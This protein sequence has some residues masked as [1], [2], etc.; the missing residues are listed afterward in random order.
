MESQENQRKKRTETRSTVV[1][2]SLNLNMN[3]HQLIL[4]NQSSYTKRIK[5]T[6]AISILITQSL[7]SSSTATMSRHLH[8]TIH[9]IHHPVVTHHAVRDL[10]QDIETVIPHLLK[11]VIVEHLRKGTILDL[12]KEISMRKELGMR[13]T[14]ELLKELGMRKILE[15]LKE[16]DIEIIPGNSFIIDLVTIMMAMKLGNN[17]VKIHR[18]NN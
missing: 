9:N 1:I 13:K 6:T 7:W 10:H 12:L 8:I 4:C 17:S 16:I 2:A 15:L 18:K 11:G 3:F 14:L 5:R